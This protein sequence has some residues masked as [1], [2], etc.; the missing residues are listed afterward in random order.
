[1]TRTSAR[2]AW[3][4]ACA[5]LACIAGSAAA[6]NRRDDG[7]VP[8]AKLSAEARAFVD[9]HNA[10]R[11]AVKEPKN[12]P[13]A[14]APLAQLEWSEEVARGAQEWANHLR[15]RKCGLVHSDARYGE[16]LAAG[17][18]IDA[19]GAVGMWA[20]ELR[21]YRYSP[22]YVFEPK[23]AHYTQVVWRKTTHVG[24][25]RANCGDKAVV[26]CRYSPAGNRIG[27]DPY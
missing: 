7:R 16:N 12:Y 27:S 9:A 20:S 24:C 8:S 17:I 15:D 11:D 22:V 13:G 4:L 2:I 18:G 21:N 10:V 19:A 5:L 1:M 3:P 6:G 25:G 23:S 26:V 14:W